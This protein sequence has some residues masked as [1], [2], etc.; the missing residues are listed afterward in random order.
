MFHHQRSIYSLCFLNQYRKQGE[1]PSRCAHTS[2]IGRYDWSRS[3]RSLTTETTPPVGDTEKEK[4]LTELGPYEFVKFLKLK[5]I[6]RCYIVFDKETGKAKAS[7][8][9]LQEIADFLEQDTLDYRQHEGVFFQVGIRTGCLLGTYIWK[10][11]RGQ[12]V[13][14]IYSSPALL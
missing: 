1:G 12:A 2:K 4:S 11:S 3:W 14:N 9:E 13:S 7:H 5:K 8:P 10:T 6:S